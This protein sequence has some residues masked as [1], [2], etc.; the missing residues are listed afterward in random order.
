MKRIRHGCFAK[1]SICFVTATMC[2]QSACTTVKNK[3]CLPSED[4]LRLYT[5]YVRSSS[6]HLS[7]Q[8]P[9]GAHTIRLALE[10]SKRLAAFD[11]RVDIKK[12]DVVFEGV[13]GSITITPD[14]R[15]TILKNGVE[16]SKIVSRGRDVEFI[17]NPAKDPAAA[18]FMLAKTGPLSSDLPELYRQMVRWQYAPSLNASYSNDV[19][20]IDIPYRTSPDFEGTLGA[21]ELNENVYLYY[22]GGL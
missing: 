18:H 11:I 20:Y 10:P 16:Q 12:G 5:G 17:I 13:D 2:L 7:E 14:G 15:R 3:A 8:L 6:L 9:A 22:F 4:Y 21:L 1:L 19:W